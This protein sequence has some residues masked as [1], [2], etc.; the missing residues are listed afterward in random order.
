MIKKKKKIEGPLVILFCVGKDEI[1]VVFLAFEKSYVSTS[2]KKKK[3]YVRI[4]PRDER[5]K[6]DQML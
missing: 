2:K 1:M 4:G 5:E 6:F 3:S